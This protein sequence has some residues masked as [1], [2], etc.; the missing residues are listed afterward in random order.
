MSRKRGRPRRQYRLHVHAERRARIDYDKL[1]EAVL[2]HAA[3]EE[4]RTRADAEGIH[5]DAT[6]Q[7]AKHA[8]GEVPS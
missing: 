7:K 8:D 3:I 5:S 1:A 2:E 4:Q 6:P